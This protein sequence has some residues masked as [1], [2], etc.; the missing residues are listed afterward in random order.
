M[1][2]VPKLDQEIFQQLNK[3]RAD[4]RSFI[5][6]LQTL[7]TKFEGDVLK[8]EGKTNLRTNE[9]VNA[10]KEAIEYL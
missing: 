9:G 3:L 10:V 4:P 1:E 5:P 2:S 8:R 7:I 6:S